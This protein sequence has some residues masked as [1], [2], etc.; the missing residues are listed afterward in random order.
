MRREPLGPS[1]YRLC[2]II[3]LVT[4]VLQLSQVIGTLQ[5]ILE[6]LVYG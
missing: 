2:L 1:V 6:K 3:L 5:A 4:I